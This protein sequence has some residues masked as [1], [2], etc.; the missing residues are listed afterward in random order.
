ML[1][2]LIA[3]S[4]VALFCTLRYLPGPTVTRAIKTP[5]PPTS[6]TAH[7]AQ[8]GGAQGAASV[9]ALRESGVVP[10]RGVLSMP[11]REVREDA[12]KMPLRAVLSMGCIMVFGVAFVLSLGPVPCIV[13]AE[14]LPTRVRSYGMSLAVAVQWAANASVTQCF[15]TLTAAFGTEGVLLCFAVST[16]A[17]VLWIYVSVPETKGKHLEDSSRLSLRAHPLARS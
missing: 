5:A 10:L 11:L 1:V 6:Y 12:L 4:L 14:L 3:S 9:Q 16:A 17:A 15:P 8:G 7:E 13:T 2:P